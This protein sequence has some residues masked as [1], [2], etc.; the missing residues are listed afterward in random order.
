MVFRQ[1]FSHILGAIL[2]LQLKCGAL[3]PFGGLSCAAC[4]SDVIHLCE[5]YQ[6]IAYQV[7]IVVEEEIP[8][9]TLLHCTMGKLQWGIQNRDFSLFERKLTFPDI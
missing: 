8:G 4:S 9:I 3:C 7:E 2:N 5:F 1:V 6:S